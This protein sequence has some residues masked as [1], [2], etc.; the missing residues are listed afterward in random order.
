[1]SKY[2]PLFISLEGKKVVVVGA[3][4][5]GLRRIKALCEF[6]CEITVIDP[7]AGR[8]LEQLPVRHLKRRYQPGDVRGAFLVLAATNDRTINEAIHSEC[9]EEQI[10]VNIAD[11]RE[12]SSFY[13][14][15][16][17]SKE[18]VVVGVT[19]GG[20]DH[21]LAKEVTDAIRKIVTEQENRK[22]DE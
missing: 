2:F 22:I 1:M 6:G 16:L 4:T 5:I 10:P 13:F 14:P 19:A 17:I 15:G 8:E 11:C 18:S 12:Q 7:A 9:E 21:R 3:G 20:T